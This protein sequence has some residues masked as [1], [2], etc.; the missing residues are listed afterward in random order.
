MHNSPCKFLSPKTPPAS[1]KWPVA[2]SITADVD[3]MNLSEA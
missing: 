3:Q 1:C 2:I